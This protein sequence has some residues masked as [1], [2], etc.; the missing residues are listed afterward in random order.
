MLASLLAVAGCDTG[1][2]PG[3]GPDAMP[4]A[5]CLEAVGRA[6]FEF[7]SDRIFRVSCAAFSSCHQGNRPA[8]GLNLTPTRAHGELV[9]V[10]AEA[11]SGWRRVV[12][13]DPDRS[14]LLVKLGDLEGPLG[15]D[16]DLMPPNSALLCPEKRDAVRSWIAAGA[17]GPPPD[18][19]LE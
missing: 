3:D 18:G 11:V 5:S 8:G 10:A 2:R 4:S 15:E 14:Y 12:P 16:G 19:G 9:D 7:V 17:P 1:L 6:D 13:G